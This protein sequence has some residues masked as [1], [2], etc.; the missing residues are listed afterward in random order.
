MFRIFRFLWSG[1]ASGAV[2]I[3]NGIRVGCT[4][5]IEDSG[6]FVLVFAEMEFKA[7]A[8]FCGITTISTSVLIYV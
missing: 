8:V 3:D 1:A 4:V 5:Q 2:D 7:V 6:R